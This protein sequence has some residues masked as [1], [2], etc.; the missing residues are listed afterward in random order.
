M[1]I[2][3][4]T[5]MTPLLDRM[6]LAWSRLNRPMMTEAKPSISKEYR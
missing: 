3:L 5:I 4:T 6:G 1:V 2:G